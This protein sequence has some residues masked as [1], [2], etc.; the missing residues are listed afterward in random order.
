MKRADLLA[1]IAVVKDFANNEKFSYPWVL[2]STE[3]EGKVCSFADRGYAKIGTAIS[4]AE[5]T[6]DKFSVK[7]NAVQLFEALS[8]I[9]EEDVEL[10][11]TKLVVTIKAKRQKVDLVSIGMDNTKEIADKFFAEADFGPLAIS[12]PKATMK[13]L[14][15]YGHTL[16]SFSPPE[17][18]VSGQIVGGIWFRGD[19]ACVL[20]SGAVRQAIFLKNVISPVDF[21]LHGKVGLSIAPKSDTDVFVKDGIVT[22]IYDNTRISYTTP[23]TLISATTDQYFWKVDKYTPIGHATLPDMQAF[24]KFGATNI[25]WKAN[26]TVEPEQWRDCKYTETLEGEISSDFITPI[27]PIPKVAYQIYDAPGGYKFENDEIMYMVGKVRG[28]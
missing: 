22:L 26:G 14:L 23:E 18:L 13:S 8:A 1:A 9:K 15:A 6:P 28:L 3:Y 19:Y 20:P 7:L 24:H 11:I 16:S 5:P 25:T 27:L 4:L 12:L 2:L 21:I 17:G 10:T